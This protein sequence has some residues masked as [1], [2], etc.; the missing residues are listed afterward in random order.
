M[1]MTAFGAHFIKE[2]SRSQLCAAAKSI[3]P[4][5]Q[6]KQLQHAEKSKFYIPLAKMFIFKNI[7]GIKK[8][9]DVKN[10]CRNDVEKVG[11]F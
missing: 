11:T 4:P 8:H 2:V 9:S 5:N 3:L 10:L 7:V 1:V 6:R